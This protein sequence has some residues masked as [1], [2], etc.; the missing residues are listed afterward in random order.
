MPATLHTDSDVVAEFL[1][2]A[3][4]KPKKKV[5]PGAKK[6]LLAN[7]RPGMSNRSLIGPGMPPRLIKSIVARTQ[8]SK[9]YVLVPYILG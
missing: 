4:K 5:I 6:M 8:Q 1:S 9:K 2:D 7:W 3:W